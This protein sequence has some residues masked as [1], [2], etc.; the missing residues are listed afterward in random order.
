MW[1]V[2]VLAVEMLE[3][4]VVVV[5]LE[6]AGVVVPRLSLRPLQTPLLQHRQA[7]HRVAP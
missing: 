7:V 1:V 2:M 5:P 4:V 3:F 6:V